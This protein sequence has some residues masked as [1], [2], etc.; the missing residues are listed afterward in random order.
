VWVDVSVLRWFEL[1]VHPLE[2]NS[3]V[4]DRFCLGFVVGDDVVNAKKM[5]WHGGVLWC[6]LIRCFGWNCF[7]MSKYGELVCY[8]CWVFGFLIF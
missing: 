7:V 5:W 6:C 3:L 8:C 1:S 2:A 4:S